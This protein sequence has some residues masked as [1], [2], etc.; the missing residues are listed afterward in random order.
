[1]SVTSI[2]RD[3]SNNVSIARMTSNDT[4][5]TITSAG[6][7]TNQQNT[8]NGLNMGPWQWF[9]T[10]FIACRASDGNVILTFTDATFSTVQ[11]YGGSGGMFLPLAGG[12]MS[13]DI[14]MGNNQITD[15]A[16]PSLAQDAATKAY[17]D[18]HGGATPKRCLACRFKSVPASWWCFVA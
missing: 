11:Q 13:G 15:M 18:A 16:D 17:V 9:I 3:S 10:D 12:T 14:D 5:A 1:M 4:I 6:Y 2:S 8:I 7:I